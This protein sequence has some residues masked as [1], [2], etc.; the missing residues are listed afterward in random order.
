MAVKL[1]I[2]IPPRELVYDIHIGENLLETDLFYQSCLSLGSRFAIISDENTGALFGK[3]LRDSLA[4]RGMEVHHLSFKSGELFKTRQTKEWLEDQLLDKGF[5]RDT[6][7]LALGGGIVTDITGFLASTYCRGISF[8]MIPTSL[9]AMVD[10]SIGGKTA[11]NVPAGKN[12]IGTIYQP[13]AIFMDMATLKSLP[14]EELK[15]G[16]VESIKHGIILDAD[17]FNFL[18]ANSK[19]VLALDF[20]ILEKLIDRS[21]RI[22]QAVVEED[23]Q[24]KGKRRLLNLGHTI[25]HALETLTHHAVSH[26]KA[27]AIG[28]M[29]ES[30]LS[31]QLNLL[32]ASAFE[33]ILK[34]LK[35]Y[36]IDT[37]LDA[38]PSP[39][40][41]LQAMKLDKKSLKSTPRFVMLKDIGTCLDCNLQYCQSV[42]PAILQ[43]TLEWICRVMRKH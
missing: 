13:N 18:E 24:E 29:A 34:I 1:T 27:V 25:G 7:L 11:V 37:T 33:R 36:H 10:A 2:K 38:P 43:N 9:L 32:P 22:K 16:I 23:E 3:K 31:L 19:Q 8:I 30:Y 35:N 6:C 15:N 41:F 17:Y 39:E 28:I 21:C 20:S 4:H 26:G 12:M 5:G 42:D 14:F 40:D